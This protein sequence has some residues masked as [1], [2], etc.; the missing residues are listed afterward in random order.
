MG[1]D[2]KIDPLDNFVGLFKQAQMKGIPDSNAISLATVNADNKP[3][4]RIVLFKG[5]I[6]QGFSFFTNYDGR[7]ARDI[8]SNKNVAATFFWS[9]L[10]LQIRIEGHAEKTTRAESEAYFATRPRLSQLGAWSSH[11]SEKIQS[12]DEV[13]QKINETSQK[14][15]GQPVPCPAHWGG[16]R[17]EP[18]EIEFWF[19]KT[20]RLH[21]RYVYQKDGLGWKRF[22]RSP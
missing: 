11:Q 5:L 7:K 20:G 12:F 1:F 2:F 6:R 8:A 22:L 16:Y 14:F 10:D 15:A 9:H 4:V 21:E 18:L 19:G 17:I 13:Q 3:S